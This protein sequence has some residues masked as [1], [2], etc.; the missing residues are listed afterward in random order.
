[1]TKLRIQNEAM[2]SKNRLAFALLLCKMHK[3]TNFDI[4]ALIRKLSPIFKTV[5]N[6]D[7]FII[8]LKGTQN[9]I[10][11]EKLP[12]TV[13]GGQYFDVR[14]SKFPKAH[15]SFSVQNWRELLLKLHKH[16]IV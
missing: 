9:H 6:G 3:T 14:C 10:M 2:I 7:L 1:M 4:N 5:R 12:F 13:L 15:F 8:R 11:I 16:D